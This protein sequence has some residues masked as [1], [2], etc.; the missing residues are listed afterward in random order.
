MKDIFVSTYDTRETSF[1]DQTGHFP[2]QSK[3]GHKYIM[4]LVKIDSNEILVEPMKSRKDAEM[5]QAYDVLVKRLQQA[6]I[7]PRKHVLDNKISKNMKQHI[8]KNYNFELEMVLPGC[9]RQNAAEVAIR[10]YKSHFLRVLAG[11]VESF[12]LHLCDRLLPQTKITLKIMQQLNATP[13]VSAYAHL[14]GPFD[15]NKMPLAPM[16]CKV[17]IHEKTDIRSMWSYLLWTDGIKQRHRNI[18]ESTT[19]VSKQ[20][21]Q[22]DSPTQ[23][24]S[25]TRI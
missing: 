14:S 23:S 8:K 22:K 10:N 16:G 24:N 15:Y 11:T 21:K 2:K 18:T 20:P 3:C 1:S 17:Q 6:N 9:H 7:H 12:P 19:A 5:I 13:T 25:S 4:V